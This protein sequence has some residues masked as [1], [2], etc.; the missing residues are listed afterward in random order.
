[1]KYLLF[2]T[3]LTIASIAA[4]YSI[5]GLVAIFAGAAIPIVIMGAALEVGKLVTTAWLHINWKQIPF[6]LKIYLTSA[7][8][9][10]MLI[11]SMGIFGFLSKA[12][13]EHSVSMGGNNELLISGLE[14]KIERQQ[15][16]IDDSETVLAQL[17]SAVQILQ[18]YD[19]IRGPD[20]AI[21]VR[22]AQ[23]EE[24]AE[25]N[26]TI[27]L[28][29][30]QLAVLQ[31]E[32]LPLQKQ[33]LELEVE[34]GPLKYIAELVY[35]DSAKDMFDEAVRLVILLLIFVFDPLAVFLLIAATS[36]LK[37]ERKEKMFY[38]DGNLKVDPNNV[39]FVEGDPEE[40]VVEEFIEDI[41]ETDDDVEI[42]TEEEPELKK[43]GYRSIGG[44]RNVDAA[45]RKQTEAALEKKWKAINKRLDKEK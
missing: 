2:G 12:H 19:R 7:V 4:W 42:I 11:T 26:R 37:M 27:G 31:E 28:A 16:I 23:A 43:H 41:D 9:V 6:L 3:S 36:S 32:L 38:E 25:L 40:M 45:T 29:Y 33:T 1:M 20:G 39:V 44:S 5:E 8:I 22:K 18:D 35:G 14:R 21:A 17:D 13:L 24:R 34:V 15:S 10:L 30:D